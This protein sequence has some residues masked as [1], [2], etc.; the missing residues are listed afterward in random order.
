MTGLSRIRALVGPLFA[1]IIAAGVL[2]FLAVGAADADLDGSPSRPSGPGG[3]SDEGG[4][5]A[6]SEG[7]DPDESE[8]D[9]GVPSGEE[10]GSDSDEEGTSDGEGEEDRVPPEIGSVEGTAPDADWH[11]YG[12]LSLRFAA[13]DK[14]GGRPSGVERV[15]VRLDRTGDD[16]ADGGDDA[17]SGEGTGDDEDKILFEEDA[18]G[19]CSEPCGIDAELEIPDE[20]LDEGV[21][22]LTIE[23]TDE[24]G[25]VEE[26]ELE[27][28]KDRVAPTIEV[29]DD[30]ADRSGK[31]VRNGS[32][33]VRFKARD[34]D[35]DGPRAGV[36]TIEVRVNGDKRA[37][38]DK[39]CELDSSCSSSKRLDIDDRDLNEGEN[40]IE[41]R[42]VDQAGNAASRTFRLLID[43]SRRDRSGTSNDAAR[44][45]ASSPSAVSGSRGSAAMFTALLT[46]TYRDVI[47]AT[48][49]LLSYWRL[50]ETS[51]SAV[52][53]QS[54]LDNGTYTNGPLRGQPGLIQGD[55]NKAAQFDG[56][57]DYVN[58]GNKHPAANNAPFTLEAWVKPGAPT[59]AIYPRIM[60]RE[61]SAN[62]AGYRMYMYHASEPDDP[63]KFACERKNAD[64]LA[65]YVTGTT[66]APQG[67][68]YRVACTYDGTT[69]R[70][71]VNG[72]EEGSVT[73]PILLPTDTSPLRLGGATA[74]GRNWS[75]IIDEAAF[76]S[77]ALSPQEN[78]DH[79]AAGTDISPPETTITGGPSGD[80]AITTPS[81]TFSSSESGSTFKCSVDSTSNYTACT[82]PKVLSAQ[83]VGQHTFR[84]KATDATGN[85]DA[86]PAERTFNVVAN[87]CTKYA[88]PNGSD[89][90][91]GT[92]AAP[93]KTP[94]KLVSSL[95]AGQTGCLRAGQYTENVTFTRSGASGS[96]ITLRSYPGE[97]AKISGAIRITRETNFI[98]V[99]KLDLDGSTAPLCTGGADCV[100]LA[101]P[102]IEGDDAVFA[103]NDVTNQH[104]AICFLVG[105]DGGPA[106][107]TVI[108]RNRIHDCGRL[109]ADNHD[110]G[111]YLNDGAG[112]R[113]EHNLI[114][115][116]SDRGIQLYPNAQSTTIRSN[117]IDGN[118][119]GIVFSNTSA[120]NIVEDNII[121]N[122]IV[123]WN[124]EIDNLTGTGNTLASNC[125]FAPGPSYTAEGGLEQGTPRFTDV[126][127]T[128]GNTIGNPNYVNK[129]GG[130]YRL[131]SGTACAGNGAPD[132]VTAGPLP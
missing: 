9:D 48:S 88:A 56:A 3:M 93:Y 50:G 75:G 115:N 36:R 107:R 63:R 127:A 47:M 109:P 89:A 83:T 52:D 85:E 16:D 69:L 104:A 87:P 59:S 110:H 103:D 22:T 79:F 49:G 128:S 62:L 119:E 76:Y 26:R 112:G 130:D 12:E 6:E 35:R 97:R 96:P 84:V 21:N 80:T 92:Q 38:S 39:R 125:L 117:T 99:R 17:D 5:P 33:K 27:I 58:V 118:G 13:R 98:H 32:M 123:R 81:F 95:S 29:S 94:G 61:T 54:P 51:G 15:R 101:S 129:P 55:A 132:S 65:T 108:E 28:R 73:S 10:D 43:R 74:A 46:T 90:N 37:H 100:R 122:S 66:V 30:L 67:A 60:A 70:V 86:T 19:D 53:E 45:K 120:T 91:Q 113:I 20:G 68:R 105:Q 111:I 121:A 18:P 7:N 24:A 23:A 102:W 131:G 57:N 2:A 40:E 31:V 44:T 11:G 126:V 78:Q 72:V 1:A 114:Y 42:S 34:E 106:D 82:S 14:D 8:P 25:N 77:R 116:N 71:F 64:G 41:V 4:E 124:G